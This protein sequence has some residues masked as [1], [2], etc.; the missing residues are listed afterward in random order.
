MNSNPQ[1]FT[2][3]KQINEKDSFTICLPNN[4]NDDAVIA[5]LSL[6]AALEN[7]G[8]N[9]SIVCANT[10]LN[11]EYTGVDKIHSELTA[12]GNDLTVSFPYQEGA[13]DKVTYNIENGNFN[14]IIKTTPGYNKMDFKKIKYNYSGGVVDNIITIDCPSLNSLGNIYFNNKELFEGKQ[15]INIDKHP[16]NAGF[17]F[18]N[19]VE[20]T[21]SVSEIIAKI[22]SELNLNIDK[23]IASNLFYAIQKNTN[24]FSTSITAEV[25]ETAAF[26]FKN[27]AVNKNRNIKNNFVNNPIEF[28]QHKEKTIEGK[29]SKI[30]EE[31]DDNF[32]KPN[33]FKGRNLI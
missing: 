7:I 29:E 5:G 8:K 14:L 26:L 20:N 10:N 30:E 9:V 28:S 23:D 16:N 13:L 27:G 24:N 32:L 31:T 18:I 21:S 11:F 19:I 17:G 25:F 33:I 22:I 1:Y 6:Y 15:I 12:E 2:L 4:L 3:S